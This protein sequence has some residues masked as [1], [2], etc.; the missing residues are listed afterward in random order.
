MEGIHD[1]VSLEGIIGIFQ[2]KKYCNEMLLVKK[3]FA[4]SALQSE[5]GIQCEMRAVEVTL[6]QRQVATLIEE[7]N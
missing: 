2:I 1:T 6:C 4:D 3:R 5:K 7:I